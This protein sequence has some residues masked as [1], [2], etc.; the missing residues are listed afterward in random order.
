MSKHVVRIH[1]GD[2]LTPANF[3]SVAGLT[4]VVYG[5]FHITAGI[6]V[7]ALFIGR[8]LDLMDG[9]IA[10]RTHTSRFGAAIDALA[11]KLAM[12]ALLIACWHF[13]VA[14]LWVVGYIAIQN[15]ANLILS[16]RTEL[17]G[18]NPE[19]NREG[20]YAVFLQNI[21]IGTYALAGI[22]HMGWLEPIAL[23]IALISLYWAVYATQGYAKQLLSTK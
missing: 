12:T 14:P 8:C 18:G 1:P 15:V 11:D 16:V 4:L 21:T 23:V 2:V 5:S 17:R 10:R 6:G 13:Q 3:I 9:P 7:L 19:A 22:A 20:K